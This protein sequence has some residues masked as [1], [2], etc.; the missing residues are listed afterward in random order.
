LCCR[1]TTPRGRAL[2]LSAALEIAALE[3]Q[4]I[5]VTT[6]RVVITTQ[7][8]ILGRPTSN[9]YDGSTGEVIDERGQISGAPTTLRNF[10]SDFWTAAQ[11]RQNFGSQVPIRSTTHDG[12]IMHSSING[13]TYAQAGSPAPNN[14]SFTDNWLTCGSVGG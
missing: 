11:V 6:G 8:T 7:A 1:W 12:I 3:A 2:G 5:N 14:S 9:F 10:T 13:I 4:L